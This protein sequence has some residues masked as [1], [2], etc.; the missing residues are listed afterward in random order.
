MTPPATLPTVPGPLCTLL[1]GDR[2]APMDIDLLRNEGSM[3]RALAA[4][5]GAVRV[6]R[7]REGLIVPRPGEARLLERRLRGGFWCREIQ[8]FAGDALRLEGRTLVPPDA[9]RLRAE[10]RRL[11]DRPLMDLLFLGD[12]LRPGVTRDLRRFGRDRRGHLLRLSRFRIRREPLLLL[13]SLCG[14]D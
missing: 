12:G 7:C 9:V 5:F 13:E 2:V 10:L 8:L 11:G 4:R 3:T 14:L 6:E 1:C